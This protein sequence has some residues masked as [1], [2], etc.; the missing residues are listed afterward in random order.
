M[1]FFA[2]DGRVAAL[3]SGLPGLAGIARLGALAELAWHLRQRDT[4]RARGLALEAGSL[5]GTHAG[6]PGAAR[7]AARVDLVLAECER[8]CLERQA[9]R[10]HAVAALAGFESAGDEE[11]AGA[12]RWVLDRLGPREGVTQEL[13]P[14]PHPSSAAA[15]HCQRRHA[16]GMACLHDGD[17]EA[18]IERFSEAALDAPALGMHELALDAELAIARAVARLGDTDAA[19]QAAQAVLDAARARG[20][21]GLLA[22][23][24]ATLAQLMLHA[25]QAPRAVALLRETKAALHE[26]SPEP[27]DAVLDCLL[28]QAQL[29]A[30]EL[31][32]ALET[33]GHAARR[34]R[35]CAAAS[36]LPRVLALQA[37]TLGRKGDVEAALER[38]DEALRRARAARAPAA[39]ID[40][41]R[42]LGELHAAHAGGGRTGRS[43]LAFL[44]HALDIAEDTGALDD[45]PVILREVAR[46]HEAAGELAA[47]LGAERTAQAC[48]AHTWRRR[49][50]DRA[51]AARSLALRERQRLARAH[52]L[53]VERRE[54]GHLAALRQTREM[55]ERLRAMGEE[56]LERLDP[57][58]MVESLERHLGA[59][60]DLH[61]LA[62]FAFERSGA[63]LRRYAREAGR[64]LP[65]REI[66]AG[67]LESYAARCARERRE[68]LVELQ[69][70]RPAGAGDLGE[71]ATL[72]FGPLAIGERVLGV[73]TVQSRRSHAY[74]DSE[75]LVFRALGGYVAA[76]LARAE[77]HD[78]L[79]AQRALRIDVE[80]Q[81][82]RLAT[83]D[84]A[85]GLATRAHFFAVA[86]ERLER[87]RRHGGPCGLIVADVDGFKGIN[88][89]RGHD[90]A[91]RVLAAVGQVLRG[92][93]GG[94]DVAG[95]TG[96]DEFALL[97]PGASLE[98]TVRVAERIR[99]AI[100]ARRVSCDGRP[101]PFTMSFGCTAI[102]DA[103]V[104]IADQPVDSTVE[105]LVREADA[106]LYE[107][108][109]TGGNRT[110]AWP[111]YQAL[112]ALRTGEAVERSPQSLA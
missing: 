49:A 103:T 6:D 53:E 17:L 85:T 41:L 105:R 108:Q 19:M 65:V 76:A 64:A 102:A 47:A 112:R 36:E 72:W 12:A 42:A 59:A 33:L 56:I 20:W 24:S 9:A 23:A 35:E 28:G 75:K 110:I 81:M 55:L 25:G 93:H 40:A 77:A 44:R 54:A 99:E 13:P 43:A 52:S 11:G 38:A 84:R 96:G 98:T 39:E 5:V 58:T 2:D 74:G 3:E 92:H 7:I 69:S 1:E 97:L 57:A 30:G 60:A 37:R 89:T 18:A 14:L 21:R 45:K 68:L 66:A 26:V 88:D 87:A 50:A 86:R 109:G 104:D 67:D 34:L 91:D 106:G 80:E 46:M 101:V 79:A 73:L 63:C 83:L 90:A 51:A 107:A 94:E 100:E 22:G 111:A 70:A 31:N 32:A 95:R 61:F 71:C 15:R 29:A 8:L 62:L 10:R 48:E 27:G 82:H 4:R 78:E 16:E